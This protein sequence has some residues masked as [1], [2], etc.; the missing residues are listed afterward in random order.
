MQQIA[1]IFDMDGVIVHTNPY[2][3][4]AFRKLFTAYELN[5]S[6]EEFELHMY[7]KH[8]SYIFS[9]FL[10]RKIG[11]EELVELE[12]EKEALF[13]EIYATEIDPIP[14]FLP[15]LTSLKEAGIPTGIATSA[16][17]ANL[18]LI[19]TK[20]DLFRLMDSVLASEDIHLHKP[21]PEVYLKSAENLGIPP[22]NCLVFED[23]FSGITAGLN[24]GMKVVGVLSSHKKEDLPVCQAYIND[25][26]DIDAK[27]VKEL[28]IEN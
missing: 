17:R 9:H 10:N 12:N 14:N 5:P 13:R 21:H 24:A 18:D 7:G 25:Y 28:M 1:V 15:F 23:S 4:L 22:E 6:E 27:W 2:H 19:A 16:P 3:S 26:T 8:N 11:R 20:L